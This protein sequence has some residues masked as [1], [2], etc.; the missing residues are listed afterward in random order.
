MSYVRWIVSPRMPTDHRVMIGS[1]AA[2]IAL[3][4]FSPLFVAGLT[5]YTYTYGPFTIWTCFAVALFLSFCI[6]TLVF[7]RRFG[8]PLVGAAEIGIATVL[9]GSAAWAGPPIS[10]W[11]MM[12][13]FFA[14]LRPMTHGPDPNGWAST[15]KKW[16]DE[17]KRREAHKKL[18]GRDKK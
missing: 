16:D 8:F 7:W 18:N 4:Y 5:L 11:L 13:G 6:H 1:L 17:I 2:S 12:V 15:L 3:L 9:F 14:A 10:P